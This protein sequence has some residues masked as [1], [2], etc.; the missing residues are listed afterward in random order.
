[1]HTFFIA[2]TG[3]G[4]GLTSI[5]LGLVGALERSGLKVGFFKPIAQPHAGDLGPERSSELIA[6]THGLNSPKPLLLSHV[7]RMLG[8][9]Q[10]DELL[11]EII[12]LYQ[13][14]AADKDVVIV[15]G[16]VPTRHASYAARVN[17]HLAKS[18]DADVILVSAPEDENLIELSDRIEIQ[19]Q[20][21]GGPKDPKVLGVILNKVR[22]EDGITAFAERL[23]E[24]SPL[25][26]SQDFRLLGCIPWQD[27][28]NAPRTKDIAELLGAR[29]LNAGDYEQ[30]RML[31]IVLCARAVANSVQLLK[32]G[33]LVVTPG[34]RDDIILSASLAAMNG[35]PLAGLLLCSDFAPDPRIMELCQGALASGLPV[36]TVS[37][38]S[39]DTATNLN[40]LNKEIP[41]DDRERAEKVSDFVA[42][43]IDHDWLSARCGTPRELRLSPPAFRYQLVQRAKAAAKR[44]VLP[45]GSEPRTVQAAAIC[46]ARGIARCVLLAKPED[47]QAVARAQGIELPEGLEILDPDLIRGRYVEPMVELRK[48]KGLNA[49][50]AEA[51][52][53]DTVVLGTMMLAL[54]EVDGLVSGAIHTTANTIRPA[55]QLIKTAPG[56]NLVSSVFFMLL[57]DQVL[58]YG[59][60]AVNPD[61]NAEQLA[62]IALQSAASAQA[63][64]IPPR[65]AMISYS[66]GDS[67]SGEEVEKVR[68]AT[69]LAREKRPDL[70]IDGPLQY[71]AAAIES[72][73]RQKAPNSP[74]AGRATVFVF[75]DLNT[76]NTTYK[77]VQRSAECISVGPMLQ[78]LRKPVNDLSRG[79]L[80]DDI[81]YTIALTAIQA[82]DLPN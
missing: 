73:G 11:E 46:Q 63:F 20:L 10:L 23:L 76:G 1:M 18:L 51:Q 9:G 33:T 69:R 5:S 6:R 79:A 48:G 41:L 19:A 66:T 16:M 7:E 30:R 68:A 55:L 53:E 45:E 71:D 82:A 38:G 47:V 50:M 8:D 64:G 14:A 59:D 28:L 65:V 62:E 36:M 15:E 70:L 26:K 22:S 56:Y 72:V 60:C 58:V 13:Q 80:V 27:E 12:S 42:G 31:K 49:P 4:V 75:P 74:V 32:P 61:P 54:D 3:F 67:G 43:H 35:V 39:Y 29:I 57:P 24:L 44:I 37:T 21:F 34:D 40:R 2:P 81:V 52:L 17:F 77:A 25:L 78:G